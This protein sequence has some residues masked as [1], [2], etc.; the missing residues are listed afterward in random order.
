M[1]KLTLSAL[2]ASTIALA[3]PAS[4][5]VQVHSSERGVG[6][7]VNEGGSG[8]RAYGRHRGCREVTSRTV[9]PNGTVVV[10]KR[11]ICR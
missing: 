11:T 5:Q 2:A 3:V 1:L 6:I 10:R 9:R 7:H 8:Y 4:A